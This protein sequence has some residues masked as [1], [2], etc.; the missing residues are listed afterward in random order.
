[1][2]P[3]QRKLLELTVKKNLSH[4]TLR[5]IGE[6]IEIENAPQKIKHHLYQLA[7]K[8]F[9][10]MD[11]KKGILQLVNASKNRSLLAVP[12]L[13]SASCGAATIFADNT[14]EGYLQ[15]SPGMLKKTKN[16]FAIQAVGNSMNRANI[17]GKNIEEGDYVIVDSQNQSPKNGQYVV[18]LIDGL[19]NI[20]RFYHDKENEQIAL[21]SES[22]SQYMPIYIHHDDA[23]AY[24]VSGVI[25]QVIKQPK[26]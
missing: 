25:L 8:G 6:L 3:I 22:T 9:I 5:Q 11:R 7:K 21:V 10:R 20:K 19:A 24:Q 15:V 2:H 16:I 23:D 26:F 1:M 14:V 17:N 13:G 12:V 18:S 4:L